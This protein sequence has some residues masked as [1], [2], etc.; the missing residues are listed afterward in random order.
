MRLIF[1]FHFNGMEYAAQD[2]LLKPFLHTWSLSVEEQFY[3][4]FPLIFLISYK[5]FKNRLISIFAF[6]ALISLFYADWG[7]KIFHQLHFI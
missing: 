5:F 7:S 1:Y 6:L 2:G 3:L 4:V